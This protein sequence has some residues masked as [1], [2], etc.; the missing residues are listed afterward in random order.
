[1]AMAELVAPSV[2]LLRFDAG[3]VDM[4]QEDAVCDH[5][6]AENAFDLRMRSFEDEL[7]DYA[8]LIE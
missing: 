5:T 7:S 3:Q 6:I 1:M 4:S 2:G 8:D